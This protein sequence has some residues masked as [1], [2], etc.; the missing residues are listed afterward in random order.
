MFGRTAGASAARRAVELETE[1]DAWARGAAGEERVAVEL[2]RLPTGWWVFHDIPIGLSG[3]NVD[4]LV[5]GVGGVF[6]LNTKHLRGHVWVG[7]RALLVNGKPTDFLPKA[8]AEG[9]AVRAR[10][11]KAAGRDIEVTPTLVFV[12]DELTIRER[13]G[14]VAVFDV[15][16]IREWLEHQASVWSPEEAYSVVLAADQPATW[17]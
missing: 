8:T 15:G 9:R 17:R 7:Q 4:H 13:P 14:D 2:D 16:S 11:S 12:T 6:C 1:R 3:T 5:I 10:L